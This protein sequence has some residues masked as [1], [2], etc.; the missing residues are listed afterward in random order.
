MKCKKIRLTTLAPVSSDTS[1]QICLLQSYIILSPATAVPPRTAMAPPAPMPSRMRSPYPRLPYDRLPP[2]MPMQQQRQQERYKEEDRIHDAKRPARLEHR[3][4]LT[5]A[6][7]PMAAIIIPEI[8]KW[9]ERDGEAARCEI[10]AV[11]IVDAAEFVVRSDEGPDEA[12]VD[13]GHENGAAAHA[14]HAEEG[15]DGPGAGEDGDDE[16]GENGGR[17]E[18]V[19]VLEAG[20]KPGLQSDC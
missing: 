15:Y 14:G 6:G 10:S 8:S 11:G 4:V 9:A 7:R 3:T 19:R 17:C 16:E 12:E 18:C 13:E 20:D 2:L 5:D 1:R